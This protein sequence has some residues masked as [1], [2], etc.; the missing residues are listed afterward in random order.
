MKNSGRNH[1]QPPGSVRAWETKNGDFFLLLEQ[2]HTWIEISL[3]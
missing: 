1:W 2:F 3:T